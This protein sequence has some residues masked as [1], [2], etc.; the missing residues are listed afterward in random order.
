[1]LWVNR[2]ASTEEIEHEYK[3]LKKSY[4]RKIALASGSE[5]RELQEEL[6][7]IKE[8]YKTLSDEE[9]RKEYDPDYEG[10]DGEGPEEETKK[11]EEEP[12]DSLAEI[13][14]RRG[15][16]ATSGLRHTCATYDLS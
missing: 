11:D 10:E 14:A 13:R 12:A 16:S 7:K 5:R 2:D 15:K 1:L 6:E 9:S 8:A 3:L 4:D